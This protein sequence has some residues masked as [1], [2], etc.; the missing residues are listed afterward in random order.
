MSILLSLENNRRGTQTKQQEISPD[1][2][3]PNS[4]IHAFIC[5]KGKQDETCRCA[6]QSVL[7]SKT[8]KDLRCKCPWLFQSS[9]LCQS[10]KAL[11]YSRNQ[12]QRK[13]TKHW[14]V[15]DISVPWKAWPRDR[16]T[17]WTGKRTAERQEL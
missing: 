2:D 16:R 13:K 17:G 12:K 1:Q 10:E 4:E 8:D 9:T 11:E 14:Q 15:R 5:K 7:S 6:F 3:L